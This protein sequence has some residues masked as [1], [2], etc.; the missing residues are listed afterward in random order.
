METYGRL[1]I[2][3]NSPGCDTTLLVRD[4][5]GQWHFDDDGLGNLQP[6]LN[7]RDTRALNGRVDVW[8]GTYGNQSCQASVEFETWRG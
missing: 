2:E 1:E 6:L 3:V 5:F 7:L 4:A 8:V